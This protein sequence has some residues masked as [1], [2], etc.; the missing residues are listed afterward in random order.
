VKGGEYFLAYEMNAS[1]PQ[2]QRK[3]F[4]RDGRERGG[5]EQGKR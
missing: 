2:L 3:G 1:E 4:G 5:E